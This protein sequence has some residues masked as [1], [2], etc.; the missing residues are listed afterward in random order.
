[1]ERRDW[2]RL[3]LISGA[4]L[5]GARLMALYGAPLLPG[6]LARQL[7]LQSFLSIVMVLATAVGL[8]LSFALLSKPRRELALVK[9]GF[10]AIGMASLWAPIVLA[11]SLY[12]AFTAAL[13]TLLAEIA[14]GGRQAA[15]RNV[16]AFGRSLVQAH[17]ITTVAFATIITP[18][19]EELIFRGALWSSI[20]RL[21]NRNVAAPRSLAPEFIK[22]SL[23]ARGLGALLRWMLSGGLATLFTAAV[24]AW[25]HAD[26]KGGAGIVR[27]VQTACLGVALGTARHATGSIVP[28][29]VLHA[30]FNLLTIAK[31]RGWFVSP[32]WPKPLPIALLY[33]QLAAVAAVILILWWGQRLIVAR[34]AQRSSEHP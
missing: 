19:G 4:W 7:T 14:A 26:Q 9:P 34:R 12:L 13:P 3:L 25:M 31:L 29:I 32:G 33:W 8:V 17:V 6:A 16:G 24:F 22:E 5:A 28:A 10:A 27:V 1:M 11:L 21:T 23:L 30:T 15:Q 20:T 2:I 18:I